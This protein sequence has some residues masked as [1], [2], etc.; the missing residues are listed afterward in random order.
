M[1]E[2][3]ASQAD[4]VCVLHNGERDRPMVY[5]ADFEGRRVFKCPK[6]SFENHLPLPR[7]SPPS[8]PRDRS[9]EDL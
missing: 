1:S 6:C 9:P 5:L 8:P 3:N 4:P 7:V 2:P